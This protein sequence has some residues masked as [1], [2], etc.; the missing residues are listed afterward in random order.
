MPN[1]EL[2]Y[3]TRQEVIDLCPTIAETVDLIEGVFRDH[4][5]GQVENPPKPA[6]HP[7][8]GAFL[9]AMPGLLKRRGLVGLKWV[10]GFFDNPARGLPSLSGLIVLNDADTGLPT[11]V[12]DCAYITALRTAAASGVAARHLA[13]ADAAVVGIVGAGLQG[14]YNLLA[15]REVLPALRRVKVFDTHSPA[16]ERFAADMAAH[17]HL[18]IA[19]AP[20]AEAALRGADVAVTATGWL[21]EAVFRADWVRPG[22]LVLPVHS[23]G[24][25]ADAV[26]RAD[27]FVVDDWQ[28]FRSQLVGPGR[29][30]DALPEPHA[31]LGQIVAGRKPGRTAPDERIID[32]NFGLAIHDVAL[33][34]EVLTRARARGLGTRLP[35]I[36]GRM[37]YS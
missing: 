32:F 10:G 11:A 31:E 22:T 3:L 4:G 18:E 6:V 36:D 12:M 14:R 13:R 23:R 20:S 37:P 2:L 27:K 8:P 19:P 28:Q 33:A 21:D 24:W 9:H 29:F 26:I 34:A 30:Y 1:Y 16:L 25:H 7:L 17:T 5:Q 35:Q 15:L